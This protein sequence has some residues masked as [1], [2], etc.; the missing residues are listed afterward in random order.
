MK[1]MAVF[2]GTYSNCDI[3]VGEDESGVN[4]SELGLGRHFE[5]RFLNFLG[6]D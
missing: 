2:F 5:L 3:I 1:N 4:A 6:I